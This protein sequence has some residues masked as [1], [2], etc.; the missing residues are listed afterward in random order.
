MRSPN[1]ESRIMALP[2][3]MYG[4]VPRICVVPWQRAIKVEGGINIVSQIPY[5]EGDYSDG[6]IIITGFCKVE[7]E[8]VREVR[9]RQRDWNMLY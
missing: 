8:G 7:E 9:A 4:I 6:S 2:K 5:K 1:V 3:G